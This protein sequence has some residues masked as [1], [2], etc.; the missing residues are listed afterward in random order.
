MKLGKGGEGEELGAFFKSLDTSAVLHDID[1]I[2]HF[3]VT[4]VCES[5]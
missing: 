1:T 4:V 2:F 3:Q 5:P